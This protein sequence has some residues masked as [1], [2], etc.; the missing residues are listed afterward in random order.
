MEFF[1]Y[2]LEKITDAEEQEL[3]RAK[4][5]LV[6]HGFRAVK[7]TTD[8]SKKQESARK[9]TAGREAATAAK[10]QN[11]MNLWRMEGEQDKKLTAYKLAKLSGVAK[12]TAQKYL[13]SMKA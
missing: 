11:G 12:N 8:K 13:D 6:K 5:V 7:I 2:R 10:I 4:D 3:D 9:A 1:G